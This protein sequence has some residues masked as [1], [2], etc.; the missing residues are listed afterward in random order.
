MGMP[1][2]YL[3]LI[4]ADFESN[5]QKIVQLLDKYLAEKPEN[6]G[7]VWIPFRGSG[8][9]FRGKGKGLAEGI[10]CLRQFHRLGHVSLTAGIDNIL[11]ID[12]LTT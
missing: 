10:H 8:S 6:A 9:L 3:F 2:K 12:S 7:K 4:C 1:N 11:L 5:G